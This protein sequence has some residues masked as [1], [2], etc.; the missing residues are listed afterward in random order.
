MTEDAGKRRRVVSLELARSIAVLSDRRLCRDGIVEILRKHGFRRV[1]GFASFAALLK[2]A[3][4]A[5]P[6]LTLVHLSHEREDPEEILGRLRSVRPDVTVVAIGTPVQLAARARD[7]DG[8]IVLPGDGASHLVAMAGTVKPR[9]RG[10]LTFPVAPEVERQS[11]TWA[12]VT[13]RQRQVL[14]LL[15][16][17]MDNLKI[18]TFLGI[19]ERAVKGHIGGLLEKFGVGNRTGLALISCRAGLSKV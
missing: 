9:Q 17:G 12:S 16:R 13:R 14:G 4:G 7:V 18:A 2:A 19:S 15:G 1:D 8:Y 10:P 11:R 3:R 6:D 5:L